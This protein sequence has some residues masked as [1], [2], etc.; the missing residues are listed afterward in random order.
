MLNERKKQKV[1]PKEPVTV[2]ASTPASTSTRK[3][4]QASFKMQVKPS[5]I[6]QLSK[7][8]H[9]HKHESFKGSAS[10]TKK[11]LL[12]QNAKMNQIMSPSTKHK[13]DIFKL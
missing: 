7:Q 12:E 10:K 8:F 9:H 3:M 11:L 4:E 1:N 6:N 13:Q 2:T 5:E